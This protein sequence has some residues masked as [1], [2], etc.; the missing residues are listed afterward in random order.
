MRF[1]SQL[2]SEK[3]PTP[4]PNTAFTGADL[5]NLGFYTNKGSK[6]GVVGP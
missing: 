4:A 3:R 5:Y 2:R 1:S 6:V